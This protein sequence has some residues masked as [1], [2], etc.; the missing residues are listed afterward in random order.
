MP[1]EDFFVAYGKQDR[2]PGEFVTG[3]SIE[4]SDATAKNFSC[5]KVSKRFDDDIS[6]V[7]GAFNIGIEG[8][9]IRSTRIAFGGM[10]AVPKRASAVEG[11][12][13]GKP[14]TRETIDAALAAFELDFRPISDAR[15][16]AA[17]RMQVAKN[18]LLRTYLERTG[19]AKD[20]H[21][22]G[23]LAAVGGL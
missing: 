3:I 14:W 15:A 9:L 19:V 6:A 12:L 17:Y 23:G 1:L 4:V 8:A 13:A 22:A 5:H 20:V 7:C 16:S 21:L 18:L 10:A 11:A 2:E